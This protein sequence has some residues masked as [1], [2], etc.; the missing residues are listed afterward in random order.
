MQNVISNTLT[1]IR[2]AYLSKKPNITLPK[3]KIVLELLTILLQEGF[4]SSFSTNLYTFQ[5]KLKYVGLKAVPA[6]RAIK[7][8][9]HSKLRIYT[10]FNLIRVCCGSGIAIIST[11]KGLLTNNEARQQNLGGELFC[12]IW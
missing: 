7:Q 4:I 10:P 2:N 12:L 9:S 8:I 6:I 5:V 3:T 1:Q 11:S